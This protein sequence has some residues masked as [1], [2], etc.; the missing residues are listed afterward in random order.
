LI[1]KRSECPILR[2]TSIILNLELSIKGF[3][4]F[5][6]AKATLKKCFA[7]LTCRVGDLRTKKRPFS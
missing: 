5:D 4:G 2:F 1:V 7:S 3:D 6:A